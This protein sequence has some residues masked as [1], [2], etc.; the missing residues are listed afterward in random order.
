MFG[1]TFSSCEMG[2]HSTF[3]IKQDNIRCWF[4]PWLA[5]GR[6]TVG[7]TARVIRAPTSASLSTGLAS[8]APLERDSWWASGAHH[9]LHPRRAQRPQVPGPVDSPQGKW[10]LA[11]WGQSLWGSVGIQ[12]ALCKPTPGD[13]EG[14]FLTALEAARGLVTLSELGP[15]GACRGAGLVPPRLRLKGMAS[16][17]PTHLA[18]L[19]MTYRNITGT[20][21][22]VCQAP[23]SLLATWISRICYVILP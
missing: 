4:P 12:Q 9:L 22:D 15:Q 16:R 11:G 21:L 6:W 19:H 23:G 3:L 1:F 14:L 8:P 18:T 20:T 2:E 5:A 17:S 7:D 10:P 13:R